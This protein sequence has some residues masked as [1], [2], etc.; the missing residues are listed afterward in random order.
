LKAREE[1]AGMAERGVPVAQRVFGDGGCLRPM[2]VQPYRCANVL[3]EGVTITNS[4][5]YEVHP[6]L[7]RNVT[8]RNLKVISHGPNNDGC[9]PESSRDVLIEGARSI[10]ATIA[11]R[12]RAG[13]TPTGGGCMRPAR[14]SLC[15]TAS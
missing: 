8:V 7:C 2:F 5:M 4:P 1:L 12:S 10:P 6:V 3:I 15:R 9:D 13:A 14:A 11:S